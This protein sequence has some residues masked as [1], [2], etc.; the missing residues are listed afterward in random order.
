MGVAA[1][2]MDRQYAPLFVVMAAG[3]RAP[4]G[5]GLGVAVNHESLHA[6]QVTETEVR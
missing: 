1:V 2:N 6:A 5:P 3:A 4:E